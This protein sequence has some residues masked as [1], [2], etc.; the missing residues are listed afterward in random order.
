MAME[1]IFLSLQEDLRTEFVKQK[2]DITD[3]DLEL[4]LLPQLHENNEHSND[5]GIFPE[6]KVL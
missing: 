3:I 2:L 5:E 6:L 1:L 4:P